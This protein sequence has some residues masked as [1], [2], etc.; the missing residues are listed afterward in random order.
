MPTYQYECENC[1]HDLEIFQ[2]MLEKRLRKCPQCGQLKLHR[3]IGIGA[4]VIF[5]G[6]GFYETDY[7]RPAQGGGSDSSANSPTKVTTSSTDKKKTASASE[8][9]L[10]S[11]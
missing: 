3:L 6:T 11:G 7:K 1:G 9:G 10:K 8:N 4:G 5:K 2:S